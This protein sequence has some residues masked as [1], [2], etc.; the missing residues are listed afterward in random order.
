[1]LTL[2]DIVNASFGKSNF[3]GYKTE[4]VDDFLDTVKE[5]YEELLHKYTDQRERADE[6]QKEKDQLME[7]MEVLVDCV[8]KYRQDENEI[9]DALISA[10][11]AAD[12]VIKEAKQRSETMMSEATEKSGDMMK[13]ATERSEKLV[14]EAAAEAERLVGEAKK[15]AEDIVSKIDG[16]VAL[17]KK[18]LEDTQT[19]VS[20]F[21]S[22]LIKLYREHLTLIQELPE[23]NKQESEE[24]QK[25]EEAAREE[26]ARLAQEAE[27]KRIEEEKQ[28]A[29]E[30]K[31]RREAEERAKWAAEEKARK[32]AEER[33]KAAEASSKMQM[34]Q[35]MMGQDQAV[36]QNGGQPMQAPQAEPYGAQHFAQTQYMT[37]EMPVLRQ[38]PTGYDNEYANGHYASLNFD[39]DYEYIEEDEE[40]KPKGFFGRRRK[41][42][43]K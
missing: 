5:S 13:S 37:R 4:D 25:N 21:R 11:K 19:L 23:K 35:D 8:E 10:Q 2:D 38:D 15:Q 43:K 26:E 16:D 6:L 9:K 12:K 18:E 41:N 36:S 14:S 24:N 39:E 20:D 3:S 30:E 27:Q 22:N 1:M 31:V 29:E 42:R 40:D 32:E 17:K 7:K 28:K 34:Q 33:A